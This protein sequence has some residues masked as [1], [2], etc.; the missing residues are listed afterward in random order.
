MMM[1]WQYCPD[2]NEK[3]R[4][5]VNWKQQ[6]RERKWTNKMLSDV[7]V[8]VHFGFSFSD[9]ETNNAQLNTTVLHYIADGKKTRSNRQCSV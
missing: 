7:V 2:D 4:D 6:Q 8:D 9:P 5:A 1:W 3:K